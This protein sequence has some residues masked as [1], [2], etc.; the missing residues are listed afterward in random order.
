MS[1]PYPDA[2]QAQLRTLTE[3]GIAHLRKLNERDEQELQVLRAERARLSKEVDSVDEVMTDL[4][5]TIGRRQAKIR[6]D[7]ISLLPPNGPLSQLKSGQGDAVVH[8]ARFG[9][10]DVIEPTSM[11]GPGSFPE[12]KPDGYCIH[13]N[14]PVWRVSITT[15]SPKGFRHSYGATCHPDDPAS[16]VAELDEKAIE[17]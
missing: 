11:Q 6:G 14:E 1:S 2:E 16:G 9:G 15:A 12:T 7:V 3:S 4:H 13:C 8:A 5:E 17:S 10:Q